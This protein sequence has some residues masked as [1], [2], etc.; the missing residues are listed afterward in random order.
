MATSDNNLRII[1][2]EELLL[3]KSKQ[4]LWIVVHGYV[5]DVTKWKD[6]K[7]PLCLFS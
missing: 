2:R 6:R 1:K 7:P 3:H 5:F 4:S